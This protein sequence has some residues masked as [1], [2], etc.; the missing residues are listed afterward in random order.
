[1]LIFKS[2]P[3]VLFLCVVLSLRQRMSLFL[4]ITHIFHTAVSTSDEN[5][6]R[7]RD[8][9]LDKTVSHLDVQS[10]Q[11][12]PRTKKKFLPNWFIK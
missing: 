3:T 5:H 1:M 8:P 10:E 6:F 12:G 11:S 4:I 2:G 7:E 9:T